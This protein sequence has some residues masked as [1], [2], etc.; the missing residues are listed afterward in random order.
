[1]ATIQI[2]PPREQLKKHNP[3]A[4]NVA[5]RRWRRVTVA[6]SFFAPDGSSP[7]EALY[8]TEERPSDIHRSGEKL[9]H[10]AAISSYV[11]FRKFPVESSV[12]GRAGGSG[13]GPEAVR[14]PLAFPILKLPMVFSVAAFWAHNETSVVGA[15]T[16]VHRWNSPIPYL[17]GG[18]AVMLGLITLALL[19]LACSCCGRESS[20]EGDESNRGRRDQKPAAAPA[21]VMQLEM[22][23]KFVVIM[24]GDHNPTCLAKPSARRREE[25]RE[26]HLNIVDYGIKCMSFQFSDVS[27]FCAINGGADGVANV[28]AALVGEAGDEAHVDA[29]IASGHLFQ[30]LA[31]SLAVGGGGSD[32]VDRLNGAT[33]SGGGSTHLTLHITKA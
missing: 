31:G 13:S 20:R 11:K 4:P 3:E 23:P 27:E 29:G 8:K 5:L 14:G 30:A 6:S 9:W 18:L 2:L 21:S 15:A 24:A 26:T 33:A 10:A 12:G 7:N 28:D 19:I 17:F 22:E 25:E 32:A 1:M 16:G